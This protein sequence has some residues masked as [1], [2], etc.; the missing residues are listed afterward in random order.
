M[1][2]FYQCLEYDIIHMEVVVHFSPVSEGIS[3]ASGTPFKPSQF[4][5][6]QAGFTTV[7]KGKGATVR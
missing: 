5:R 6:T 7:C 1:I 3:T 2:N 4:F